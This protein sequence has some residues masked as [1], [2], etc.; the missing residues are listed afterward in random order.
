ML[1]ARYLRR[2][3]HFIKPA[4][5]SRGALTVKETYFIILRDDSGVEAIG[6]CA[7]FRGLGADDRPDYEEKVAEVCRAVN[8]GV[9]LPDLSEW[10]SI[11]FGLEMAV[12]GIKA[13]GAW[14]YFPS[15]W[16]RGE[17]PEGIKINGLVWMDSPEA[18]YKA[19]LDK[20]DAGFDC[21]KFKVGAL[22]FGDELRMIERF[23]RQY[24]PE[25][26][27]LRLDAN[28][29]WRD[30][31]VALARLRALVPLDIHSLEQPVK[32]R[33]EDLMQAVV[34]NSPVPIALDEELIGRDPRREA[35]ALLE[36]IRPAYIILKPSLCGGFEGAEQWIAGADR[37][38]IGHWATSALESNAGLAAIAQWT[39][40]RGIP[41]MPQGLGTGALY[42]DN[43]P[44]P[45]SLRGQYMFFDGPAESQR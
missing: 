17:T 10:S 16:S 22:D 36:K 31:S 9:Q 40:V 43:I 24:G 42:L 19:A 1:T 21:I 29:A 38:G 14:Q 6:E 37:L 32:A 44:S 2:D 7:L 27:E 8:A 23:R 34:A 20:V 35:A 5:T 26:I 30:D 33:Q 15:A 12:A 3:F 18:M 13:G 41:V 28:G 39:A 11:R 4:V 45:L 25:K